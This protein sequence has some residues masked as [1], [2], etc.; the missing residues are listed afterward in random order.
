LEAEARLESEGRR[1]AEAEARWSEDR[2]ALAE[3][4]A[5]LKAEMAQLRA[6]SEQAALAV[7]QVASGPTPAQRAS[8]ALPK[9]TTGFAQADSRQPERFTEEEE[10]RMLVDLLFDD[11]DEN[12]GG[13][14]SHKELMAAL[15]K[16]GLQNGLREILES[17]LSPGG[18][19]AGQADISR[20]VFRKVFQK[21]PRVRGELVSWVRSLRLEEQLARL[22][23][24]S[25]GGHLLDGLKGLKE[26]ELRDGELEHFV[27]GVADEFAV[28]LHG[29]LLAGLLQLRTS[30]AGT[31]MSHVNT[32]FSLDGAYVGHFATLTDFYLGPEALNGTPNPKVMEGLEV[33]HCR[34]QN[35]STRFTT[36]NYNLTTTPRE[37]W[38]FVV[39]PRAGYPYA[40]TPKDKGLWP[41]GCGWKGEEGREVQQLEEFMAME[42][43]RRAGLQREEVICLRLYSGPAYVLY[44]A[45]LRGFPAKDVVLLEGNDYETTIFIVSSGITKLSKVTGIPQGRLLFRGLGGMI[46]PRQFWEEFDECY[47]TLAVHAVEAAAVSSEGIRQLLAQ[48]CEAKAKATAFGVGIKYLDLKGKA[49]NLSEV[50]K[51]GGIRVVKA[52]FIASCGQGTV[53]MVVALPLSQFDLTDSMCAE[54]EAAVIAACGGGVTVGVEQIANKP[55]DFKGGGTSIPSLTTHPSPR[56]LR[57]RPWVNAD[58]RRE[59]GP[60]HMQSINPPTPTLPTPTPAV[61][62]ERALTQLPPAPPLVG[63][64]QSNSA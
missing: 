9:K 10:D 31:A 28:V 27:R 55:F 40:H 59:C 18:A 36:P 45:R 53:L 12:K 15:G 56:Y 43:V 60:S 48:L 47:V 51:T 46:L 61:H 33:E 39:C 54:L 2:R 19:S 42:V 11:I 26:P 41:P 64:L 52:P 22:I 21:L 17:L 35:A 32:K 4:E 38:E 63:A 7:R 20:E 44:N 14:I 29:V 57:C 24:R 62:C 30:G 58:P 8:A 6:S 13:T 3:V 50:G 34:R 23:A 49:A 5:A 1:H 25:R 16:L 37:E